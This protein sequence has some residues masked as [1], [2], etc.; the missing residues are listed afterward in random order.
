[1]AVHNCLSDYAPVNETTLTN[2]I[3]QSEN[4]ETSVGSMLLTREN[5]DQGFH[6]RIV[7]SQH[8]W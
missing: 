7:L 6:G 4:S 8:A 2:H 1:M 5:R 3:T